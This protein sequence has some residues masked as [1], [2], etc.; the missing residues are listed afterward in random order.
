MKKFQSRGPT[1]GQPGMPDDIARREFLSRAAAA[2]MAFG[3]PP[4]LSSCGGNAATGAAPPATE[5]R[6]L[7]FNLS[8]STAIAT[9]HHLNIAGQRFRLTPVAEAPHVLRLA[10]QGNGFLRSVSETSITHHVEASLPANA[11]ALGYVSCLEDPDAGTWAMSSLYLSL[12]QSA[13]D[14]AAERM[15]GQLQRSAKRRFYGLPAARGGADMREEAMLVDSHDH[16]SAMIGAHAELLSLDPESAAYIHAST[17]G[18][19]Q[20]TVRLAATLQ[21]RGMATVEQSPG[22]HNPTGWATLRPLLMTGSTKP[23]VPYRKSDG[24]L[25]IYIPDWHPDVDIGVARAVVAVHPL[26][27]DDETLG[28]DVTPVAGGR[29]RSAAEVRGK[30]WCRRDGFGH[31]ER[32]AAVAA[33]PPIAMTLTAATPETGLYVTQPQIAD[34]GGALSI[35]LGNVENWFLRWLGMWVRFYGTDR[36]AGPIPASQLPADTL[37][38]FQ[39][40]HP[41]GSDTATALFVGILPQASTIAGIPF[42]PGN[43]APVI[44]KPA[45]A[46]S[47]E[48]LYGGLGLSGSLD[49]PIELRLPGVAST[50][51]FNYFVVSM[52][53]LAGATGVEQT[54]GPFVDL[55]VH[56]LIA[57]LTDIYNAISNH[58]PVSPEGLV[59]AF[60][61][62]VFNAGASTL[63]AQFVLLV[64]TKLEAATII[65][66]VPAIGTIARAVSVTLN[67]IELAET[68]VEIGISP[69]VYHF[70]LVLTHTLSTVIQPQGIG[71]APARF[72]TTAA[73]ETL[74]Y[75]VSYLF[76]NGTPHL[77]APVDVAGGSST[78]IPVALSNIPLGGRVN[79]IVGFY[80]RRAG[81]PAGQ[82]DWCAAQGSTGLVDNNGA[83]APDIQVQN[84]KKPI[85]ADTVYIHTSK[86][87]LDGSGHH[88]WLADPDGS[89]APA[90]LPP[91]GDQQPSLGGLRDITIRQDRYVGYAWQGYSGG[92]RGCASNAPGQFDYAANV[93]VFPGNAEQGYAST[94]C[95]LASG[96]A[97]SY[98]LLSDD[99]ANVWLDPDQ[100]YLRPVSLGA[101]P[102]F[103]AP[104][105]GLAMGR[106]NLASNG[107]LLHPS[108]QIVSINNEN[109]KLEMLRM[110]SKAVDEATASRLH[111]ARTYAGMGSRPGLMRSPVAAAVSSDGVILVLEGSDG[112]NR[113]QAFDTGGNAVP[114][115]GK[116][117]RP[118]FLQLSTAGNALYLDLAV[119]YSGYLYVLSRGDG[120]VHRLDIYHAGQ[121]GA[122]PICSTVG[123]NAARLAV[124]F[125]RSVYT[126]N[127]EVLRLP[128]GSIPATLT[129]PSISL[130]VPPAPV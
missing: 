1:P 113:I 83:T 101:A 45:Q 98:S 120:D 114:Y 79:I 49:D 77:M 51:F 32:N 13:F 80:I 95:G 38:T 19:D 99:A 28:L 67:A 2:G 90:F 109:S 129:E 26:V 62:T 61:N 115:F 66:S 100:L 4:L 94:G 46:A 107:L 97:L 125:W 64:L 117:P 34:S 104:A 92:H 37:S 27:R 119:E 70:D 31:I 16:A 44:K 10:R 111:L 112:N 52:F 110:P 59:M 73:G 116:Q 74:Y 7:F 128:D 118:Y 56:G 103:P 12:P 15:R 122:A 82:N 43:F 65:D 123:I 9:D 96:S 81:T 22:Q 25:N 54:V 72:P 127:Y 48:V 18:P 76:D 24:K 91:P 21:A 121:A 41:R 86:M 6:L 23:P 85:Q 8:N 69:P 108:G 84:I 53:L 40:V 58:Q 106:L 30:I 20:T 3:L 105:A 35:S 50:V 130:W 124:D 89:H 14:A 29:A 87:I 71:N 11:V 68:T 17:I 88:A 60:C 75:R 42:S 5:S 39:G 47:M 93:G 57:E 36:N 55:C 63:I 78:P 126:L 33:D 102:A